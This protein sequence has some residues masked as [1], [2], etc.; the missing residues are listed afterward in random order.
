M[1]VCVCVYQSF[2]EK[3]HFDQCIVWF[4]SVL[5]WS[6]HTVTVASVVCSKGKHTVSCCFTTFPVTCNGASVQK[7][8][9]KG[10]TRG[11]GAGTRALLNGQCDEL[12]SGFS[13]G[14][15]RE[16]KRSMKYVWQNA[17]EVVLWRNAYFPSKIQRSTLLSFII[18]HSHFVFF[19][20]ALNA[21]FPFLTVNYSFL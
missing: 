15:G 6:W 14:G 2:M 19:N 7:H 11:S 1:C 3:A 9:I 5:V 10:F 16:R 20:K 21:F 12:H 8:V 4:Q 17:T 13:I 18:I